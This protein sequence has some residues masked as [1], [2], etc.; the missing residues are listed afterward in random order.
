MYSSFNSL[1]FSPMK[2]NICSS[3]DCDLLGSDSQLSSCLA[4]VVPRTHGE[5]T[6]VEISTQV[7]GLAMLH[8]HM[9]NSHSSSMLVCSG[10]EGC[11]WA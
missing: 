3:K 9:R 8:L 5:H 4:V 2:L 6:A 1:L 7:F 11:C 10:L